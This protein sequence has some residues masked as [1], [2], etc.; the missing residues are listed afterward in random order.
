MNMDFPHDNLDAPVR[1]N[2][3]REEL[4]K[5]IV[6]HQLR[7]MTPGYRITNDGD[8]EDGEANRSSDKRSLLPSIHSTS[9]KFGNFV[10]ST[11]TLNTSE[12]PASD[13]S[14]AANGRSPSAAAYHVRNAESMWK[15]GSKQT[16]EHGVVLAAKP[17]SDIFTSAE[18]DSAFNDSFR[19]LSASRDRQPS[20]RQQS[21]GKTTKP[22]TPQQHT[23]TEFEQHDNVR[24]TQSIQRT[25]MVQPGATNIAMEFS[26]RP[27]S[28]ITFST[29]VES[30]IARE[31]ESDGDADTLMLPAAD[32]DVE[33]TGEEHVEREEAL[34]SP[35]VLENEISTVQPQPKT[36]TSNEE[37]AA[38]TDTKATEEEA[39][40][41]YFL[42]IRTTAS[43]HDALIAPVVVP[44]VDARSV[45]ATA[46]DQKQHERHAKPQEE[47][48][49][50][51]MFSGS[52]FSA[53]IKWEKKDAAVNETLGPIPRISKIL[54]LRAGSSSST[55]S[56]IE[57]PSGISL[58]GTT[59]LMTAKWKKGCDKGGGDASSSLDAVMLADNGDDEDT[60]ARTISRIV[61]SR[62]N[63]IC[64]NML[65]ELE[66]RGMA[67]SPAITR[68]SSA[69]AT[70]PGI[71]KPREK[72]L[73]SHPKWLFQE[74]QRQTTA[75]TRQRSD[76]NLSDLQLDGTKMQTT[77][78]MSKSQS[79]THVTKKHNGDVCEDTPIKLS[80]QQK[81]RVWDD[82]ASLQLSDSVQNAY[83]VLY[84]HMYTPVSS[85]VA[86]TSSAAS[87][88]QEAK[89]KGIIAE[90]SSAVSDDSLH[91]AISQHTPVKQKD[92]DLVH[93][94]GTVNSD[95][96]QRSIAELQRSGKQNSLEQDK[97]FW[98]A[99]E[100]FK[101]VGASASILIMDEATLKA[102]RKEIAG[103]IYEQFIDVRSY[104]RLEWL[105]MYPEEVRFVTAHLAV[106]PKHLFNM[107]QQTAQLRISA[108]ISQRQAS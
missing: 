34:E 108:V 49:P 17:P 28:A 66:G 41:E 12:D 39:L 33:G 76:V 94:G 6:E 96:R 54:P 80:K 2:R 83:A 47:N 23:P 4:R 77:K 7:R 27:G 15:R 36:D 93:H 5:A 74:P 61:V 10:S 44:A 21:A 98:S 67:S 101:A 103:R 82:F 100:G 26:D 73:K 58:H 69:A 90:L 24:H 71:K 105:D 89:T 16:S 29:V 107:L 43:M 30:C 35:Q 59:A 48:N 25:S 57:D 81:Q 64:G 1:R 104:H 38:E 46:K 3:K 9:V 51:D 68:S 84:P 18:D 20:S 40:D 31:A 52:R 13:L 56:T 72:A 102:K 106:A 19:V 97:K 92:K 37:M 78:G 86:T 11:A 99:V 50:Q 87:M 79:A 42:R 14:V 8:D 70:S 62:N 95:L 85:E 22:T 55:V 88:T 53:F 32:Q 45:S 65:L 91:T 63:S 75:L 60:M